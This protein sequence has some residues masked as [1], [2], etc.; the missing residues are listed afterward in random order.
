MFVEEEVGHKTSTV[1]V[2]DW[3][4]AYAGIKDILETRFRFDRVKEEKF[5]HHK[6]KGIV[7]SKVTVYNEMDEHTEIEITI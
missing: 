4:D 3:E 2:E 7:V 5:R 6:D 1:E